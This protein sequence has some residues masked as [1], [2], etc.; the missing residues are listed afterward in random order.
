MVDLL[1]FQVVE[2]SLRA[3]PALWDLPW[4]DELLGKLSMVVQVG[5]HFKEHLTSTA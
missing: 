5:N 1:V 4:L 2:A 3:V